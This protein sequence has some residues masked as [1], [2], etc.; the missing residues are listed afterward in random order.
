MWFDELMTGIRGERPRRGLVPVAL[1]ALLLLAGCS[2]PAGQTPSGAQS[3][4][5]TAACPQVEGVELPPECAPYDP[6]H[7]MAQNDRHR[8]R[9]PLSDDQQAEAEKAAESVRPA[10][11]AIVAAGGITAD[12]V[13]GALA[14][15]GLTGIQLREG[16]GS[17]LFGADGP[18]G[19]CV[20]GEVS[21]ENVT[22]EAGGY[23]MDG[24]CLPAN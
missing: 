16:H 10:L 4:T 2:T 7:S 24:G 5:P 17:V 12:A 15:A 23:I 21:A 8:E 13:D 3:P 22:I 11:E 9:M 6:E 20:F 14:E 18:A 1:A 19:G